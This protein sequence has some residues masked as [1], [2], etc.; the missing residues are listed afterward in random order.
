MA[1]NIQNTENEVLTREQKQKTNTGRKK[2]N[3]FIWLISLIITLPIFSFLSAFGPHLNWY[4]NIDRWLLAFIV[5]TLI[6]IIVYNYKY[7]FIGIMVA[8]VVIFSY[9]SITNGWGWK[10]AGETYLTMIFQPNNKV[11]HIDKGINNKT[12]TM[13]KTI[14]S[15]KMTRND[16]IRMACN[17]RDSSVRNFALHHT[18]SLTLNINTTIIPLIGENGLNKHIRKYYDTL[19]QYEEAINKL[20]KNVEDYSILHFTYTSNKNNQHLS[21]LKAVKEK[22]RLQKLNK[23]IL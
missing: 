16:E 8:Y 2:N 13:N 4:L 17:Y 20:Q 6:F 19:N 9:G 18:S 1:K 21:Q 3:I 23:I 15:P 11:S 7:L 5:F 12:I 10:E 22:N 14:N